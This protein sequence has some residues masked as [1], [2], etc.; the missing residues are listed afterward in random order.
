MKTIP[1][2]LL[3]AFLTFRNKLTQ[4]HPSLHHV[5][6]QRFEGTDL[7]QVGAYY[8]LP[9]IHPGLTQTQAWLGLSLLD[10]D[11]DRYTD[12]HLVIEQELLRYDG[13]PSEGPTLAVVHDDD[14]AQAAAIVAWAD[15]L[16]QTLFALPPETTT[17]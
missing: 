9:P 8:G 11:G 2:G 10:E 16:L 3:K 7:V 6:E 4:A 5:Q 15:T 13:N 12:G 1:P 17:A 14:A